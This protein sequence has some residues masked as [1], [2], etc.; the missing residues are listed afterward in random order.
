MARTSNCEQRR[1]KRIHVRCA[2]A[3]P[4][5]GRL[6]STWSTRTRTT[7]AI[8]VGAALAGLACSEGARP[9]SM[10]IRA[11]ALRRQ[12]TTSSNQQAVDA[13]TQV[14]SAW[15]ATR[16]ADAARAAQ[17]LAHSYQQMGLL[18][19]SSEALQDGLALAQRAGDRLLEARVRSDLG[20]TLAWV[21]D[22]RIALQEAERHCQESLAL[23]RQQHAAREEAMAHACLGEVIYMQGTDLERALER[24]RE[25]E[26]LWQSVGDRSGI[27]QAAYAQGY[28]YSDLRRFD[29]ADEALRRSQAIWDAV[30]DRR[31]QAMAQ[32]A[33][34]RLLERRG[35]LQ[36][37]LVAYQRAEAVLRVIGDVV[38]LASCLAGQAYVYQHLADTPRALDYYQ[39]A[40]SVAEPSGLRAFAWE[41][42]VALGQV[43]LTSRDEA[44]SLARFKEAQT[45]ATALANPRLQAWALVYEG[46]AHLAGRN[47]DVA[48]ASFRQ[49]LAV[50]PGP[51]DRTLEAQAWAGIAA[52]EELLGRHA[53]ALESATRAVTASRAGG[54]RFRA[55]QS[56]AALG[57]LAAQ[58]GET[59]R[60]KDMLTQARAE[61]H[62]L[63]GSEHPSVAD[64]SV[65]LADVD[66]Q[67][68]RRSA[69]LAQ[70]LEAEATSL[71]H[72]MLTIR[73]LPER[74]ALNFAAR[75]PRGM[76]VAL[77]AIDRTTDVS[78]VYDRVI[79]A[80]GVILDELA[81]RRRRT[82][83]QTDGQGLEGQ[84]ALARQRFANQLVRSHEG[85]VSS[86]ELRLAQRDM[87]E[88]E[89]AAASRNA[90]RGDP[91]GPRP[92]LSGVRAALPPGAAL[93]SFVQFARPAR[94]TPADS[95][96]GA[97]TPVLAAFVVR[98]TDA[99]AVFVPLG[100]VAAIDRL[101]EDW[102]RELTTPVSTRRS[103]IAIPD[104]ALRTTG[105]RLRVA[106]WDPVRPYLR[107]VSR[108]FIVPDG[109][110]SL[111]PFASLPIGSTNF[112]LDDAP[113]IHYL[114]AE[115]D[116]VDWPAL[117]PTS[118]GLLALGG[119]SFDRISD[120]QEPLPRGAAAE[121]TGVR[122]AGACGS[123]RNP[124]FGQL[125]GT[126]QEVQDVVR[127]WPAE[128][129][130]ARTLVGPLA[131]ESTLKL[132][133][134]RFR[135]LHLAT[136]GFFLDGACLPEP[137]AATQTRGVGGLAAASPL[138]H[139]LRLSGLAL[140]GANRRAQAKPD[141]DDGILTAE[142]VA[143][144]N[145]QGFEWAVLSACD[146]GVGEIKAGEG[147]FG[148]RRAFQVAG[149]RTVIMS[150]WSVEDQATRAWMRALYEGRFQ[151]NLST[152]DAVHQASLTVL[153]DRRARGLSTH[154]FYWAAFVAAGDWR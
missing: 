30:G 148:L 49:A 14:V 135:V 44:E 127:L 115:R 139:P 67:M 71:N 84:A 46:G 26:R 21:G 129:G 147:V 120:A 85:I 2:E 151:R 32:V 92:G 96:R 61:L 87:E 27:A 19:Q 143:T 29:R 72:L 35:D 75:R 50:L 102:R 119:P 62:A 99:P 51:E 125:E 137:S 20:Y 97:S 126:V 9:E 25:A 33:W 133:G 110:L 57:R 43:Y 153:R 1:P 55:A 89:L 118:R 77:A 38:W 68:G 114:T 107:G 47:A 5:R 8:L 109:A 134:S 132:E 123:I 103:R 83:E 78:R 136:H 36:E 82:V 116:M 39:R 130:E 6:V 81:T 53:S 146:T 31:S 28:L 152:A 95:E 124:Q 94:R 150:L 63:F 70:A 22:Q 88:A 80:R 34:A 18:A 16:P 144:L 10:L 11:D 79:L 113:P 128:R 105:E 100:A 142:E 52:A 74:Q 112:V 23:A 86:E 65:G 69:A 66:L 140:A 117:A 98:S 12:Q 111:V 45:L 41:M 60:A 7:G 4:F 56:L 40:L 154:P 101:V 37:A 58:V 13:Y 90:A 17:G 54:D 104:L 15:R 149:A 76:D 145:L 106:V 42:L 121:Q 24:Q 93:V 91:I 131:S 48:M 64:A 141:E 122:G 138:Q 59:A 3:A 108:V 73:H